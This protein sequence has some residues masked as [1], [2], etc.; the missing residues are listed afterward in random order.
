MQEIL[1]N[2]GQ[3]IGQLGIQPLD[4]GCIA[5]HTASFLHGSGEI[6]FIIA[7]ALMHRYRAAAG[8]ATGSADS[9]DSAGAADL[10]K[11]K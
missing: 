7:V 8:S 9:S 11:K 1:V 3:F 10:V 6:R 5:F 2:R 4:D